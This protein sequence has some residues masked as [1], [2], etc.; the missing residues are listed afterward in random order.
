MAADGQVARQE[1]DSPAA[2]Y[3]GSLI[4]DGSNQM[5]EVLEA[6]IQQSARARF[7]SL[8]HFRSLGR[9]AVVNIEQSLQEAGATFA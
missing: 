4:K 2:M 1:R 6:D 7:K 3:R 9:S 5:V 8:R